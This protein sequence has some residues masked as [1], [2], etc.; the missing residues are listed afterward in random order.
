MVTADVEVEWYFQR[1]TKISKGK[2][3]RECSVGRG[4]MWGS[5]EVKNECCKMVKDVVS[6]TSQIGYTP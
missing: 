1:G 3:W 5:A 4:Q 6:V 2:K